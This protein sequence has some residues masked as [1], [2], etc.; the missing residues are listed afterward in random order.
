MLVRFGET[1][2]SSNFDRCFVRPARYTLMSWLCFLDWN[3]IVCF[4]WC[5]YLPLQRVLHWGAGR[6]QIVLQ[7]PES[8]A[9]AAVC[10]VQPAG[11]QL[12]SSLLLHHSAEQHGHGLR[13]LPHSA[14]LGFPLGDVVC[15]EANQEVL[16]DS[17]CLHRGMSSLQYLAFLL[18]ISQFLL[19]FKDSSDEVRSLWPHHQISSISLHISSKISVYFV[20]YTPK[21]LPIWF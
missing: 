4:P 21:N 2:A 8:S 7:K 18:S 5:C 20:F 9:E 6:Q 10:P 15:A 16:D 3:L 12:R 19:L 11:C 17:Y 1:L 13:D 14:H